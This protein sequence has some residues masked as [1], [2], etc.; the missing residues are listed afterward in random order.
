VPPITLDG[1]NPVIAPPG[2]TT[3]TPRKW[4]K[5]SDAVFDG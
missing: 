1:K 4:K 3:A 2:C 5:R